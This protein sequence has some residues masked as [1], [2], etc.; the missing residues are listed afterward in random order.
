PSEA[1]GVQQ[2][3]E[4]ESVA[5]VVAPVAAPYVNAGTNNPQVSTQMQASNA[6]QE[7]RPELAVA[8][9]QKYLQEHPELG[10][11]LP[12]DLA[13]DVAELNREMLREAKVTEENL[14]ESADNLN[15]SHKGLEKAGKKKIS[16]IEAQLRLRFMSPRK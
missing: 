7:G 1:T 15:E 2:N 13:T 14:K 5:R 16:L 10:G 6:A 12:R 9:S 3:A 8:M 4:R 11:I